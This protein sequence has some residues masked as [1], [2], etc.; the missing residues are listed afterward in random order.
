MNAAAARLRCSASRYLGLSRK[1][2]SS[3]PAA[4]SGATSLIRRSAWAAPAIAAPVRRASSATLNGPATAKKRGSAMGRLSLAARRR[5]GGAL[6][7]REIHRHCRYLGVEAL[8]H[9][10]G[11]VDAVAH[12]EQC[13]LGDDEVRFA[14]L[15]D[16]GD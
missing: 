14:L 7:L 13:R 9:V 16:V 6:L 5:R 15:G 8:R 2:T 10:G 3:G 4:S 11:H 1:L 12:I